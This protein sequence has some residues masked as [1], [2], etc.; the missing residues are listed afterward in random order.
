MVPGLPPTTPPTEYANMRESFC[1]IL[2]S[3][4]YANYASAMEICE[5]IRKHI[6][7]GPAV[8]TTY[9]HVQAPIYIF[10]SRSAAMSS[11]SKVLHVFTIDVV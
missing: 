2:N 6:W 3:A 1:I 9:D 11:Y 7:L 4:K 5:N 8:M 10:P